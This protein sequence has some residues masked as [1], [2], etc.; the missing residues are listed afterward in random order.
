MNQQQI[1]KILTTQAGEINLPAFVTLDHFNDEMLLADNNYFETYEVF[2]AVMVNTYKIC[3]N[4]EWYEEMAL[5][6]K[7]VNKY[8]K[9]YEKEIN[10][11]NDEILE[12]WLTTTKEYY[13]ETIKNILND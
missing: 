2:L 5:I 8:H 11:M 4:N 10:Q 9:V 6:E 12:V 13:D 1:N 7:L 3:L